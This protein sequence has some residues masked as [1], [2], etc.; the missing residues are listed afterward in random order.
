MKIHPILT[1]TVCLACAALTSAASSVDQPLGLSSE[2]APVAFTMPGAV[3][4]DF[5]ARTNRLPYR[6]MVWAPADAKTRAYPV[7][8]LLDGNT[9]FPGAAA[10]GWHFNNAIIVGIGVP[11]EQ[12]AEWRRRRVLDL[13]PTEDRDHAQSQTGGGIAFAK[14][15]LEEIK[16]FI[17]S[18]YKIEPGQRTLYG[19]SLGGLMTTHVMFTQ[20]EA[21]DTYVICSPILGWSDGAVLKAEPAFTARA[22]AGGFKL[23]VLVT[24]AGDESKPV[25]DGAAALANRLKQLP[26][27][28]VDAHYVLFEN[29][30]HGSVSLATIGR[31]L[32]FALSKSDA[33]KK[34]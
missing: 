12:V 30:T 20:P 31:A 28:A 25:I 5:T 13:T 24:A 16:P 23:R 14:V 11:T 26:K 32:T 33:P 22:R 34:P 9:W 7:I 8:Y 1:F 10:E 15:L 27:S 3:Q 21:F 19:L 17:E 6:V 18:V 2:R 4:Y 29:E